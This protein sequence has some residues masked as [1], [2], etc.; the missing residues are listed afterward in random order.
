[1]NTKEAARVPHTPP[2]TDLASFVSAGDASAFEQVFD[3]HATAIYNLLLPAHGLLGHST[4]R[5]ID[6]LPRGLAHP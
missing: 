5:D 6:R 4:G 1:V 3:R 2:D